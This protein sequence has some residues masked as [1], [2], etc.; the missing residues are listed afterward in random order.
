MSQFLISKIPVFLRKSCIPYNAFKKT[1]ATQVSLGGPNGKIAINEY[2][3]RYNH[4][5]ENQILQKHEES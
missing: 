3:F 1:F 5:F 4:E 2:R